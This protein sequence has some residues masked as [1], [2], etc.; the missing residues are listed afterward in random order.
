MEKIERHFKSEKEFDDA[1]K[2]KAPTEL[3]YDYLLKRAGPPFITRVYHIIEG[4]LRHMSSGEEKWRQAVGEYYV[5]HRD[6]TDERWWLCH[7]TNELMGSPL[8][9]SP[10]PDW[11]RPRD[12]R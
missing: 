1:V 4:E 8:K 7:R 12:G 3:D 6:D 10:L 2:K 5:T 9:L 11:D